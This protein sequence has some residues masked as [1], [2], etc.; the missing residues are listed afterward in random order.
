[1]R[2]AWW[3]GTVWPCTVASRPP[4]HLIR[5]TDTWWQAQ[6]SVRAK[7]RARPQ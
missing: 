4:A 3:P 7:K 5:M 1:M 6:G 2:A